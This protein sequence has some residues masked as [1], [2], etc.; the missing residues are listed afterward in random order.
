MA[1]SIQRFGDVYKRQVEDDEHHEDG[2]QA[3]REDEEVL[4]LQ[5]PMPIAERVKSQR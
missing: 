5:A 1:G 2:Q 3:A 4:R